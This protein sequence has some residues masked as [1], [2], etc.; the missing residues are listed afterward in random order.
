[1]LRYT[2][3]DRDRDLVLAARQAAQ[4][5]IARDPTLSDARNQGL[6]L[7]VERRYERG[8]ELFRVG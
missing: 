2:Q 4:G 1:M 5:L 6:R 3:L 8:I 7:R